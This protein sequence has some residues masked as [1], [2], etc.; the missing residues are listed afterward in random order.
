MGMASGASNEDTDKA[1]GIF[2]RAYVSWIFWRIHRTY[3]NNS[4]KPLRPIVLRD[5]NSRLTTLTPRNF[6]DNR[7]ETNTLIPAFHHENASI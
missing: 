4:Q 7:Y 3:E 1:F 2:C 5:A 6:V